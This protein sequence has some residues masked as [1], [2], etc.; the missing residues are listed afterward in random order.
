LDKVFNIKY[1]SIKNIFIRIIKKYFRILV[2]RVNNE[3]YTAL[4][5]IEIKTLK[6]FVYFS[7]YWQ[8][9]LYFEEIESVIKK[10]FEFN[11]KLISIKNIETIKEINKVQSVSLHVRRGDYVSDPGAKLV[12]GGICTIYYYKRAI[13]TIQSIVKG[14]IFFYIFTDDIEWVK[15]NLISNKMIIVDWNRGDESWQDMMLMSR[16]KHNIIANS[17]FSWWGAWLNTNKE[18]IVIAPEKWFNTMPAFDIIP[19][20]WIRI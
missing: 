14:N 18:K 4:E 16:C 12:H 9:E 1:N 17:S 15:N 6:P 2:K 11:K 5:N 3:N 7:G 8:T 13:Q 10:T 20:N 19:E